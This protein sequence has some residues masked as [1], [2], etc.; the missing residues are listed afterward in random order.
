MN[1]VLRAKLV[2]KDQGRRINVMGN[3]LRLILSG[4]DSG[5]TIELYEMTALPG[6]GIPPHVHTREDEIFCVSAG[7]VEFVIDGK[8]MLLEAGATLFG[9][10]NV[11]HGYTVV[12]DQPCRMYFTVTPAMLENM[13]VELA[14][15]DPPEPA[16]IGAICERFGIEF[17]A[18]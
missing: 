6:N 11:S 13:F 4:E 1:H 8:T 5:G 15:L 16:K 9:A 17:L 2:G 10:R 14:E 18:T 7:Q 12:G 3:E